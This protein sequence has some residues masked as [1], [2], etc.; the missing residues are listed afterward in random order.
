M[1]NNKLDPYPDDGCVLIGLE[2]HL[3]GKRSDADKIAQLMRAHCPVIDHEINK[4]D[5]NQIGSNW[6]ARLQLH[7]SRPVDIDTLEKQY[8][9]YD[10]LIESLVEKHNLKAEYDSFVIEYSTNRRAA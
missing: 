3:Q 10:E 6:M 1:T 5:D 9:Y 8:R 7:P 2:I 4:T